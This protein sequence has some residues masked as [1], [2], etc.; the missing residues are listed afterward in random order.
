MD[1]KT[2]YHSIIISNTSRLH[3]IRPTLRIIFASD[4]EETGLNDQAEPM[5]ICRFLSTQVHRITIS[6]W[7]IKKIPN[8][9]SPEDELILGRVSQ[10]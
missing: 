1:R 2:P 9:Y 4:A 5:S 6:T 7:I 8:R 10:L 3:S